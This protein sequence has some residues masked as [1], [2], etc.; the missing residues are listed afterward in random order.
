[1]MRIRPLGMLVAGLAL[2][3][4]AIAACS[5]PAAP[6]G[7]SGRPGH[8]AAPAGQPSAGPAAQAAVKTLWIEFF[9]GSVPIGRR[10]GLLQDSAA[11][12][13][14]VRSQEKTTL[15]ALVL[16]ATATVSSVTLGPPAGASVTYTVLLNGKPLAKN[17]TGA[18]VY[19]GGRWLVS[20]ATFCGLLRLAYPAKGTRL[21]AVCGS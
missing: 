8:S 1:M 13:P 3:G 20:S 14:F 18:A 16:E 12:A 9:N 10:L 6:A 2:L 19:S 11:F 21:P 4:P 15:G 5:G 7:S 17:L